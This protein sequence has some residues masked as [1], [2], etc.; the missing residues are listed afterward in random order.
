MC[1]YNSIIYSEFSKFENLETLKDTKFNGFSD[2]ITFFTHAMN[3]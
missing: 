3:I 1:L 2:C